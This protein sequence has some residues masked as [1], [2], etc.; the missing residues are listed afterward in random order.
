[1]LDK[2]KL[3]KYFC[4]CIWDPNGTATLLLCCYEKLMRMILRLEVELNYLLLT[5]FV[6]GMSRPEHVTSSMW[7]KAIIRTWL[8]NNL[9]IF[10]WSLSNIIKSNMMR[11]HQNQTPRVCFVE[12]ILLFIKQNQFFFMFYTYKI[13][14]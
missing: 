11:R 13:L 14:L 3:C 5:N 9:K 8:E 7:L 6:L 4:S 10:Q 1:M 12:S 2:A